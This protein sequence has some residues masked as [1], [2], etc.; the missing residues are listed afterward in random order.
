M[1]DEL[2]ISG[3][4]ADISEAEV[5]QLS[6]ITLAFVG[7]AV[8]SLLTREHLL[9]SGVTRGGELHKLTVG[10]VRAGAQS[11]AAEHLQQTLSD[12]ERNIYRRGR[13][14]TTA[15]VP[16]NASAADY[17][18]ATGLEA[19][20]GYLYLC[21]RYDRVREVFTA[22]TDFLEHNGADTSL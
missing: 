13:N 19:L 2:M 11:L 10:Y 17:R 4:D 9:L 12:E 21:R 6:P 15:H 16:R 3:A 14:A 22:V 18:H 8:F 20:F 7:D 5:T 1:S